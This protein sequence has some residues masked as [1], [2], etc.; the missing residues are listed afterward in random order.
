MT[1]KVGI[2]G[3]GRIGRLCLRGALEGGYDDI[4]V[5]AVN[6]S[7]D[8]AIHAHMFQFDS[9]HG[10]FRGEVSADEDGMIINGKKIRMTHDRN[11]ANLPW[12]ELGVDIVLECTGAFNN[13]EGASLHLQGGAKKVL[14]SAPSKDVQAPM[15]VYGVNHEKITADQ[16]VISNASC[17]TNCL[18]PVADVLDRVVGIERG[19]MTTI[20]AYTGDQTTVD[21]KHKDLRRA[22]AAAV[23]MIPT[24]TGAAKAIGEVLPNLNRKLDGNAV[25]VPTANV[26]VIDLTFD[27]GRDTS[28]EEI[29]E[30][31]KDAAKGRLKGVLAVNELPLVSCDFNH[32]DHSSIFDATQT[33]VIDGRFV[34]VLSW[35]D[36]EWGF[37]LRMLD[38]AR[39]LGSFL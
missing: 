36:N 33:Q 12:A 9:V 6:A 15:F 1:L 16:H 4:E 32:N 38:N 27:A 14:I 21:A 19:F 11:P 31:M 2:N 5:V 26:S 3:F 13:Y 8:P 20:H 18:A 23:S 22:R 34:R 37:S 17:T 7:G 25:R 28:V 35:Y 10:T 29:N 30:A 39:I 24:S